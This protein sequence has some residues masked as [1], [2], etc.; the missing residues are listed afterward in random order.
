MIRVL[1]VI[2]LSILLYSPITYAQN[3]VTGKVEILKN[4]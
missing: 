3:N 1:S 4:G 2:F